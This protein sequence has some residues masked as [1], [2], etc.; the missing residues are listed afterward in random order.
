MLAAI[1]KGAIESGSG[2][3][4]R[5]IWTIVWLPATETSYTSSGG[6][7]ASS[8]T[9]VASSSS[10]SCARA[11]ST[12][13]ASASSIVAETREMTSAPNGCCLF[14]CERTASGWPVSRSSRFATTVVVPRSK[15]IAKVR[16]VVSPGST[17]R[18]RSSQRTAV[19]LK[20]DERSVP[21]SVRTSSSETRSSTSSIA[22]STRSRSEV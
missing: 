15:A 6:T 5:A 8:H 16:P 18:S 3:I 2:S 4:P 22:A 1:V 13:S 11:W 12:P 21:P 14:S 10:V 7:P 20:S 17:S 19:T 9:S